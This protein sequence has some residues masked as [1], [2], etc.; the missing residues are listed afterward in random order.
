MVSIMKELIIILL[1]HLAFI[2]LFS[3]HATCYAE[4]NLADS[5]QVLV[6]QLRNDSP[7][8]RREAADALGEA[9]NAAASP[10]IVP[11]LKDKDDYVR[12]AAARAM[13]E[14]KANE[15]VTPLIE[16]LKDPDSYVRSYAIWALGEINDPRGVEPLLPFIYD[17]DEKIRQRGSEAVMKFKIPE[18]RRII[19]QFLTKNHHSIEFQASTLLSEIAK[20]DGDNAILFAFNDP[21]D[22]ESITIR[23]YIKALSINNDTVHKIINGGLKNYKNRAAVN[24]GLVAYVKN[25]ADPMYALIF[26]REFKDPA[27]VAPLLDI[28]R[29]M[30]AIDYQAQMQGLNTMEYQRGQ[31]RLLEMQKH[32]TYTRR[33]LIEALGEIENKDASGDL[34][35]I[36]TD[37]REHVWVRCDAATALGQLKEERAVAPLIQIVRD[38]N[39]LDKFRTDA[40]SALGQLQDK[41]AVDALIE[42]LAD[43]KRDKWLRTA[44]AGSLAKIGDERAT[45]PLEQAV[46][47]HDEHVSNLAGQALKKI[48]GKSDR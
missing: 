48:K 17:K 22:N 38:N 23:N 8:T 47:D 28:L 36:L 2:A 40:A 24:A 21:G 42:V 29:N 4:N 45:G 7:K 6:Q 26:I 37:E 19:V 5:T 27:L 33:M 11:L 18:A 32:E 15:A 9:G 25:E 43:T 13:G 30:P 46:R 1:L 39:Q 34:L 35:K 31:S 20:Q 14:L 16:A 44:A 41:K 12:Q 3:N 10:Y